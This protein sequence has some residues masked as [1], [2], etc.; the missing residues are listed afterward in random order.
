MCGRYALRTSVPELARTLGV[1]ALVDLV[2][3]YN[4]APTQPVPAM[5][6]AGG[7]RT[8]RWMRW[9]LVPSWSAG[10]DTRYAM[11]NA[12]IE[13]ITSKAAYR[14]PVRNKRCL[15][16]VS[17]WYE[18]QKLKDRKQPWLIVHGEEPVICLAG[19]WEHWQRDGES[20][21]SC[22]ILT[23][24]ARTPISD[25]HKR[26]PIVVPEQRWDA[27][28]DPA[29]NN[30]TAALEVLQ[31]AATSALRPIAVSAHVNNARNDDPNCMSG[32]QATEK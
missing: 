14:E 22:S 9:G 16:P 6:T 25:I 32:L 15:L 18:W 17:G 20:I 11:H 26:M 3:R 13:N 19:V 2:P 31:P 1:E 29:N 30:A 24:D 10:P 4:I 28:L 5:H 7:Q 23:T 27:W 21:T 8:L 12:R